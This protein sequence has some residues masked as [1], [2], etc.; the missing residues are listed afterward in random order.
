MKRD[1]HVFNYYPAPLPDEHLA[2]VVYR[3]FLLTYYK[4]IENHI[5]SRHKQSFFDEPI[6]CWV[7]A[8]ERLIHH[9]S[10]FIPIDMLLKRHSNVMDYG[11]WADKAN[12]KSTLAEWLVALIA[13]NWKLSLHVATDKGWRY[14]PECANEEVTQYG[15]SYWHASYQRFYQRTCPKHNTLLITNSSKKFSLPPLG[16]ASIQASTEEREVDKQLATI[17]CTLRQL[18]QR[19]RKKRVTCALKQKLN[20]AKN[21]TRHSYNGRRLSQLHTKFSAAINTPEILPFFTFDKSA[22]MHSPLTSI[23]GIY[24]MLNENNLM[25]PLWY[26]ILIQTFLTEEEIC[27]A[28]NSTTS[29]ER[30]RWDI[31]ANVMPISA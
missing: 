26:L 2:S 31:E 19:E 5:K 22:P 21:M 25:H 7:P 20:I 1:R 6:T 17:V 15:T 27:I 24:Q 14:C 28:F 4:E 3:A 13:T 11:M 12:H 9:F 8:Y 23:S 16:S 30:V 10:E 18:P 29:W